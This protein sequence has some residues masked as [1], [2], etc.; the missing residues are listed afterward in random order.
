MYN[1]I[2]ARKISDN[3]KEGQNVYYFEC[4]GRNKKIKHWSNL[5][6]RTKDF[7]RALG[8]VRRVT[9]DKYGR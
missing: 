4:G 8:E 3:L 6:E 1:I 7:Y 9:L 2:E 5:P